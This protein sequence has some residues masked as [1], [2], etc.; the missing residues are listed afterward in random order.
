MGQ[1][2]F[3]IQ[4]VV[5]HVYHENDYHSAK[6]CSHAMKRVF[7]KSWIFLVIVVL[8]AGIGYLAVY[9]PDSISRHAEKTGMES[10]MGGIPSQIQNLSDKQKREIMKQLGGQ[11]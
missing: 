8:S 10:M 1:N 9:L 5:A 7:K 3:V 11:R 2:N 6:F 4:D